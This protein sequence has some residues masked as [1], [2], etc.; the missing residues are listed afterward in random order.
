MEKLFIEV[1]NMSLISSYIILCVLIMRLFLRKAPKIFSYILWAVV[2]AKLIC[3]VTFDSVIS[4]I[5]KQVSSQRIE[6]FMVLSDTDTGSA[7]GKTQIELPGVDSVKEIPVEAHTNKKPSAV[8]YLAVI[9]LMGIMFMFVYSS[10][11][12]IKL[13][14]RLTHAIH[15]EDNLYEA[16]GIHSPFVMGI[17]KPIIYLPKDLEK[18]EFKYI[19]MHEQVHI[20][21][22]DYLIK[23]IAFSISCIHWFNPLVWLSFLL[24]N[25]DMEMSC[26]ESVLKKL[27]SG[28]KKQYSNSLLSMAA[29]IKMPGGMPIAFG[30]RSIKDRIKNVLKYRRPALWI[31]LVSA[32][33]VA[34]VCLGLFFNPTV[35]QDNW[36]DKKQPVQLKDFVISDSQVTLYDGTAARIRLLMTDGTYY[37]EEYAGAGGGTYPENY[38]GNYELQLVDQKEAIL[39]S[40]DLNSDWDYSNINYSGAFDI[41]F[42]DY[43]GDSCPDFTIGTYGSSNMNLYFVYTITKDNKIKRI[44]Q[45]EIADSTKKWSMVFEHEAVGEEYRFL[46]EVYNNAV[47]ET[48][49]YTY[50]WDEDTGNFKVNKPE[51]ADNQE[52]LISLFGEPHSYYFKSEYSGQDYDGDGRA[53]K[54]QLNSAYGEANSITVSFGNGDVLT[55]TVTETTMQDFKIFGVDLNENGENEIIILGDSGAQGGDGI[56][57]LS[58]YKKQGNSYIPVPLP[59]EYNIYKGFTYELK[60]DGNTA[61]IFNGDNKELMTLDHN[62]L[63]EHY[64]RIDASAEWDNLQGK[65]SD[66]VY[67]DG[68]CDAVIN[69]ESDKPTLL[70]KQYLVGPTGVHVDCIGYMI[71]ELVL[72]TDNSWK[73]LNVYYLPSD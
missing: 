72:N 7:G 30:E 73:L 55:L 4:L 13:K 65:S 11:G 69:T 50:L 8:F 34:A 19:I 29:E 62:S 71:T 10:I 45:T 12:Y 1:L 32:I 51:E 70:L 56:Y 63:A 61:K 22:K 60:W 27:G 5:P 26:D 9:W 16:S 42:T 64:K 23:L 38:D 43:N 28:I 66:T 52:Y 39:T 15:L 44:C 33:L 54:A 37:D 21:R 57:G 59:E 68:V 40:L 20:R 31:I 49:Q 17:L 6:N 53:D 48:Q 35:S 18:E 47:G 46:T 24:M 2:F 58:I 3:P 67:A 14:K 41:L 25:R 36:K